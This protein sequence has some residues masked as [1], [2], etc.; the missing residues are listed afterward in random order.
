MALTKKDIEKLTDVFA[1]KKDLENLSGV[2]ATKQDLSDKVNNL[3]S[4]LTDRILTSQDK[5]IKKIE[6]MT[7]EMK[8]SYS[9]YKRHDEQLENHEKRIKVLE[10]KV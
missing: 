6:D 1:T 10:V 7:I 4:E 2:F 3:R 5:I 8:M 9:Q